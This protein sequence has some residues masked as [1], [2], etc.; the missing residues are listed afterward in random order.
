[1]SVWQ[2]DAVDDVP[3]VMANSLPHLEVVPVVIDLDAALC[4]LEEED[5]YANIFV[6]VL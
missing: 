4:C 3:A 2:D 1:M 5:K 6:R